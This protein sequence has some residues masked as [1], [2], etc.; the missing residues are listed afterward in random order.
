MLKSNFQFGR[1]RLNNLEKSHTMT[2]FNSQQNIDISEIKVYQGTVHTLNKKYCIHLIA[3]DN[4]A[5]KY[6]DKADV[7]HLVTCIKE[8]YPVKVDWEAKQYIRINLGWDY[9]ENEVHLSMKDYV[10]QALAQFKH[11]TPK[12]FHYNL[13]KVNKVQHSNR[14]IGP[15]SVRKNT[16][17]FSKLQESSQSRLEQLILPCY[18]H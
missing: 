7:E 5:I 10:K 1:K 17:S 8:R 11:K 14:L 18:M 4:F 9:E 12:Q 13:S 2:Q 16:N 15:P 6:V 3:I